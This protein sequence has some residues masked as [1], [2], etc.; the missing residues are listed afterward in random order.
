MSDTHLLSP[1]SPSEARQV[2]QACD[3]FEAA[4]NAGRRPR[5][6]EY[7]AASAGPA[8]PALL[9]QLLIL[10]WDYRRRAGE[11]P[12][13]DEY[14]TRFPGDTALVEDV[15]REMAESSVSTGEWPADADA[16]L[17]PWAGDAGPALPGDA[18]DGAGPGADRYDLV[19]EIGRGGIGKVFRGRD[20]HLG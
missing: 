16:Q 10:D 11:D 15:G 4:W 20:R 13:A 8:R 2:V 7:L 3:R 1:L 17:T 18:D 6:E 5:P 19:G 12:R 14:C 9:R